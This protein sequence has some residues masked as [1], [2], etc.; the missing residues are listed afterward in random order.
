MDIDA[1]RDRLWVLLPGT[2]CTGAVFD[3]FLDAVGVPRASRRVIA[4]RHPRIGDYTEALMAATPPDAVICGFSLG[5]IVAAHHADRLAAGTFLLFGLNPHA[6]D[7]SKAE[8]RHALC[9]AVRISGAATALSTRLPAFN[10]PRADIAHATVL[11]MAGEAAGDIAAQTDLALHRP[12]ALPALAGAHADV[13]FL[14]GSLDEQAPFAR[15]QTAAS[16]TPRGRAVRL[17]GLGHFALLE[18]PR[19][20]RDALHFE[21]DQRA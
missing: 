14:T 5:A 21:G 16:V 12:G 20:C 4:L 2:L 9:R 18:D 17:D 19:A 13:R 3:G 1:L 11:R 6:D 10:G 7:P 8:G 15:A